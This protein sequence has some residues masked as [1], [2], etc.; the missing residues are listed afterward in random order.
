MKPLSSHDRDARD[1]AGLGFNS[2]RNGVH[3]ARTVMLG[4]ISSLLAEVGGNRDRQ[5][6]ADA[7]VERNVLSKSTASSRKRTLEHLISLY[8]LDGHVPVFRLFCHFWRLDVGG[9]PHIALVL[10]RA[11]DPLLQLGSDFILPLRPGGPYVREDFEGFITSRHPGRFSE[12]TCRSLAQNIASTFTQTGFLEGK[13]RKTRREPGKSIGAVALAL[14][15]GRLGADRAGPSWE[16]PW[17]EILGL[18]P[19]ARDDAAREAS[20]RGWIDYRRIGEVASLSFR[21]LAEELKIPELA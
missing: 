14:A 20:R 12:K 16:S 4:E 13:V 7:V 1:L 17:M 21:Q 18:S 2:G 8:A 15:L 9:R 5:D 19:S 11:R 10:A 6:Y 3:A